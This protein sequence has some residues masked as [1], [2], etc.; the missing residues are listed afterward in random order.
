MTV[1]VPSQLSGLPRSFLVRATAYHAEHTLLRRLT[2]AI[3]GRAV[4]GIVISRSPYKSLSHQRSRRCA[5][6]SA[7]LLTAGIDLDL[8]SY[9]QNR[10]QCREVSSV[11]DNMA[12]VPL[13]PPPTGRVGRTFNSDLHLQRCIRAY[14]QQRVPDVG[15]IAHLILILRSRKQ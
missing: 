15:R 9:W 4:G 3:S 1:S 6:S 7:H 12:K 14:T 11:C 2:R 13:S 8:L 5:V 10:R